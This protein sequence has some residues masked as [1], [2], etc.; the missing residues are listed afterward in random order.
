MHMTWRTRP[1]LPRALLPLALSLGALPARAEAQSRLYDLRVPIGG[2][3]TGVIGLG[4]LDSDGHA[5]FAAAGGGQLIAWSGRSATQIYKVVVGPTGGGL[6]GVGDLD[7]DGV[8]DFLFTAADDAANGQNSGAVYLI[9]GKTGATLKTWTGAGA[10]HRFGTCAALIGDVD[11]DGKADFAFGAPGHPGT[12]WGALYFVSGAD[13]TTVLYAFFGAASGDQ[14]G[15]G[16][17]GLGDIDA[18]GHLDYAYGVGGQPNVAASYTRVVSGRFRTTLKTITDTSGAG[19]GTNMVG[20]TLV[21]LGDVD[22]DGTADFFVGGPGVSAGI[23][24]VYSG[25]TL[26]LLL[27]TQPVYAGWAVAAADLGDVD[28]DGHADFAVGGANARNGGTFGWHVG[29]ARLYSGKTGSILRDLWGV[30]RGDAV[31]ASLALAGDVDRDGRRDLLVGSPGRT[32]FQVYSTRDLRLWCETHTLSISTG[33]AAK[34]HL[35]AGSAHA[36]K[37]SFVVGSFTG[38]EPGIPLGG[39]LLPLAFDPY[40]VYTASNPNSP[41]LPA[42]LAALDANGNGVCDFQI[43]PGVDPAWIGLTFWHAYVVFGPGFSS[44]DMASNARPVRLVN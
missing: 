1:H 24:E 26:G 41:L 42:S 37:F 12:N 22:A 11:R 29:L 28:G 23:G 32:A 30:N 39:H 18:D 34:Y 2:F 35:Q 7:A 19:I 44:F 4:D 10:D 15:V 27:Q 36:G 38:M 3:G 17:L 13:R 16:V 9:T 31:G 25:K 6:V 40:L 43:V 33:G 21:R 5:D 14:L 20:A 8:Q